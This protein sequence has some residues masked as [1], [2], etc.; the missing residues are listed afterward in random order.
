[1]EPGNK[2][3]LDKEPWQLQNIGP[4]T[5]AITK[6]WT[7]TMA[8]TKHW[9]WNHGNYITLDTEQWQSVSVWI[10]TWNPWAG[11]PALPLDKICLH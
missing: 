8:I 10:G 2:K 6:H 7:F 1:M 9:T 3:T 4:G 5:M 11:S